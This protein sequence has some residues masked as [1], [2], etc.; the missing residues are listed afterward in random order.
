MPLTMSSR[1]KKILLGII[2]AGFVLVVVILLIIK[3]RSKLEPTPPF[4]PT[5]S[6]TRVKP[7]TPISVLPSIPK[8]ETITIEGLPVKNFYKN[9]LTINK[10]GY[11]LIARTSKYQIV[12]QPEGN[13][14]LISILD[15]PVEKVQNEAEKEFLT[16]LGISEQ[17]ACWL[18]VFVSI[19]YRVDPNE[20]GKV[21][22]LSFCTDD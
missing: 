16:K 11:A 13:R 22:N 7:T 21:Y 17:D 5:P 14:F 19:D 10:E 2:I 8:G 4:I 15:S 9:A 20:G 12:Y 18:G 1:A 6:V 3:S